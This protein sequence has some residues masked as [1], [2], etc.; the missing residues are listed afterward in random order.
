MENSDTN[1]D[2]KIKIDRMTLSETV[3][4]SNA[5]VEN[6]QTTTSITGQSFDIHDN[7]AFVDYTNSERSYSKKANKDNI[8][9]K[10]L[11]LGKH[12]NT[13]FEGTLLS[14]K[15]MKAR[16]YGGLSDFPIDEIY[17]NN[18]KL[19]EILRELP[20]I[21]DKHARKG[22]RRRKREAIESSSTL[23]VYNSVSD[24]ESL[25][26]VLTSMETYSSFEVDTTEPTSFASISPTTTSVF[27]YSTADVSPSAS[28]LQFLMSP[29]VLQSTEELTGSIFSNI[30]SNQPS[31]TIYPTTT[32][33]GSSYPS[34]SNWYSSS[35]AYYY[36]DWASWFD[37]M[38]DYETGLS[39]SSWNDYSGTL[40][41]FDQ[42]VSSKDEWD[43]RMD[44]F[45]QI[46]KNHSL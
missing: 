28:V 40:F 34:W 3:S 2:H 45:R 20:T 18:E 4:K 6:K 13:D 44:N 15:N 8:E 41:F 26:P 14:E 33:E 29:E 11:D 1:Y 17:E 30:Y 24:V 21:P 35:S 25:S 42:L 27:Q 31:S 16:Q 22:I 36:Y 7:S 23:S 9:D 37:Y 43:E 5:G 38:Y 39:W 19:Y 46:F 10:S 12:Q 32:G